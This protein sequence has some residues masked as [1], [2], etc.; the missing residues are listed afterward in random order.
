MD[1]Y[2]KLIGLWFL[3]TILIMEKVAEDYAD[4]EDNASRES[5][6]IAAGPANQNPPN[7]DNLQP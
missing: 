2:K 3:V 7:M 1:W 4:R 5:P 6:D